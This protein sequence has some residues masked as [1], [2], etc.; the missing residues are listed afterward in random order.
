MK[1]VSVALIDDQ[2][3]FVEGFRA[4]CKREPAIN[5]V[6]TSHLAADA[7]GIVREHAPNILFIDV[8]TIENSFLVVATLLR[9][10]PQLKLIALTAAR[11]I[12]FAI[13]TL[14][15]GVHGYILKQSSGAEL[16][17][18]IDAI[19]RG[20]KFISHGFAH[21]IVTALQEETLRKKAALAIKLSGR[22]MQVAKLLMNGKTNKEIAL[23]L[24]VSE[25]T[26]KSYMTALM[27]KLNVRN[28]L[29]AVIAAQRLVEN[30]PVG[31]IVH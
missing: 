7:R 30:G 12:A 27:H 8:A 23:K 17:A 4:L 25:K 2:P 10:S 1:P 22:E 6:A 26:V 13:R 18:A 15:A 29:E 11:G 20:E 5:L 14:D 19:G 31:E 9:T 21:K 24:S 3:I 16:I 28:R